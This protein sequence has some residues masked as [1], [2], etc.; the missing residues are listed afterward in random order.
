MSSREDIRIATL[1]STTVPT[2]SRYR[3]RDH[4]KQ[5]VTWRGQGCPKCRQEAA[6]RRQRKTP[7]TEIEET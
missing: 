2:T 4:P 7:P 1:P 5:R 6:Q 3:C